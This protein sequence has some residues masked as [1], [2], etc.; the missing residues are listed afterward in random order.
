MLIHSSQKQSLVIDG[1]YRI[2]LSIEVL[3]EGSG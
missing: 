2:A 1:L 3:G